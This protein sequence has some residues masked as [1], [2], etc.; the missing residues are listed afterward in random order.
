VPFLAQAERELRT[1]NNA[2]LWTTTDVV[3]RAKALA[4]QDRSR[5]QTVRLPDPA[6]RLLAAPTPETAPAL[7][8]RDTQLAWSRQPARLSLGDSLA[9]IHEDTIRQ[10]SDMV[11]A[12]LRHST[13]QAPRPAEAPTIRMPP[14]LGTPATL[15]APV[16][17]PDYVVR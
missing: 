14:A 12:V 13:R 1:G 3:A 10:V 8:Y 6:L 16:S 2:G 4:R 5:R 15:G 11:T 7:G 9:A 17:L